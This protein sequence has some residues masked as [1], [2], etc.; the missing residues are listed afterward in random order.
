MG[1][2][3][4][5]KRRRDDLPAP[6]LRGRPGHRPSSLSKAPP[7]ASSLKENVQ[8]CISIPR[9]R[10]MCYPNVDTSFLKKY[11]PLQNER[12]E[13]IRGDVQEVLPRGLHPPLQQ[14]QTESQ[15][16]EE[17]GCLPS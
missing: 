5:P 17:A 2:P 11:P 10:L 13:G 15:R 9:K 8:M 7:P 6:L 1:T 16:M 3:F 4:K 12:Q 14:A